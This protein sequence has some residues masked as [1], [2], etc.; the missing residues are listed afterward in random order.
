MV[1]GSTPR[2][3]GTWG[4][5][6]DSEAGSGAQYAARAGHPADIDLGSLRVPTLVVSAE[7]DFFGTAGTARTIVERVPGAR[8]L[9]LPDGG[10]IWLGHDAEVAE[11]IARFIGMPRA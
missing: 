8:L 11:A 5:R 3:T 6:Q 2:T 9:M 4:R 1:K 10:H 7:D